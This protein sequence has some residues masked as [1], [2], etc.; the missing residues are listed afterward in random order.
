MITCELSEHPNSTLRVSPPN[1]K[2]QSFGINIFMNKNNNKKAIGNVGKCYICMKHRYIAG[3][4]TFSQYR[5][6][7]LH[8]VAGPLLYDYIGAFILFFSIKA[9]VKLRKNINLCTQVI[10]FTT[11]SQENVLGAEQVNLSVMP[12]KLLAY[13]RTLWWL[14]KWSHH[15][16]G[17]HE[18]R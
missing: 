10:F 14:L 9:H 13:G 4:W 12:W 5:S 7:L 18:C 1:K 2:L 15:A 11:K 3:K 17:L 16:Q 8:R 6:L